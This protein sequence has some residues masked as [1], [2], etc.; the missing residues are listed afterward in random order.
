ML[1]SISLD[2]PFRALQLAALTLAPSL[3]S[4]EP[5]PPS[6]GRA[7]ALA[8]LSVVAMI[9][10]VAGAIG[11]RRSV[12]TLEATATAILWPCA[13]V[14]CTWGAATFR[15]ESAPLARGVWYVAP[16]LYGAIAATLATLAAQFLGSSFKNK[17]SAAV[18]VVLAGG[19]L[20]LQSASE[21]LASEDAMWRAALARTPGHPRAVEALSSEIL[22]DERGPAYALRTADACLAAAP[23]R[24]ACR[25]LR[26]E[27]LLRTGSYEA[28]AD[29]ASSA[30]EA[31]CAP[32]GE[33]A[34]IEA[35]ALARR[36]RSAE[37]LARLDASPEAPKG[38]K[39]LA[40][41]L[42]LAARGDLEQARQVAEAAALA[43]RGR[44][45]ELLAGTLAAR[46]GDFNAAK[47]WLEPVVHADPSQ[48]DAH[49][50]LARAAAH[51]RAWGKAIAHL[52]DAARASPT[53]ADARYELVVLLWRGGRAEEA[54]RQAR[55]F[56]AQ[57]PLDPRVRELAR[58]VEGTGAHEADRQ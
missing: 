22:D 38:R 5:L 14:A 12:P 33:L 30:A 28:A 58:T 27:A 46:L 55:S 51:E 26:A 16:F 54:R 35:E 47:G 41:A 17:R 24:C 43:G 34:V 48:A 21:T 36:G 49:Y 57:F 20:N 19:L 25:A 23:E 1:L 11:A 53:H 15:D 31:G 29:V 42:A 32:A 8:G 52:E 7:L 6:P 18:V 4:P 2:L 3:A 56:A 10:V 50:W 45:A 13:V 37:A 39:E 9:V 40:R 44:D